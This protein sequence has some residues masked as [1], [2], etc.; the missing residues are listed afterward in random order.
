MDWTDYQEDYA[1]YR[2]LRCE[3]D[4]GLASRLVA[5][6]MVW[7]DDFEGLCDQFEAIFLDAYGVLQRGTEAV[8]GGAERIEGWLR[9]GVRFRVVSNNASH[10]PESVVARLRA[11]GYAGLTVDRVVTSGMTVRPYWE[12]ACFRG[13]PYYLVGSRESH[14]AYAPDGGVGRVAERAWRQAEWVL[15]CSNL[16]YRG[17]DRQ[18]SEVATLAVREGMV[19]VLANPDLV[20]PQADGGWLP[21]AGASVAELV[22]RYG[23]DWVGLGKPFAPVFQLALAGGLADTP[24]ERI[25]MV[26]D[27]LATDILGGAAMGFKTCLTLTGITAR[28]DLSRQCDR[29]GIR[30]DFVVEGIGG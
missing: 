24:R 6:G 21:V 23:V 2:R 27:S 1:R 20:V 26:G 5:G 8:R 29:L 30:P 16:H 13:R 14:T 25:L 11:I 12:G 9:R 15:F 18:Q 22:K 10:A 7:V 17:S 3:A 4:P 28:E 19:V